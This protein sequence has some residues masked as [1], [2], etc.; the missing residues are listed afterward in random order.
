M[1]SVHPYLQAALKSELAATKRELEDERQRTAALDRDKTELNAAKVC[2]C[3]WLFFA[4]VAAIQ[5]LLIEAFVNTRHAR[6]HEHTRART[7]TVDTVGLGE[8]DA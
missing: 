5:L 1:A 4:C 8:M 2:F 6:T 7:H 3:A